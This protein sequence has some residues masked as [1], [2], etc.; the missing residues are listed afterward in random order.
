M[1]CSIGNLRYSTQVPKVAVTLNFNHRL[2]KM[3]SRLNVTLRLSTALHASMKA[4]IVDG[5]EVLAHCVKHSNDSVCMQLVLDQRLLVWWGGW[6]S[7]VSM[8]PG[9]TLYIP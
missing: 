2:K 5:D 9:D 4:K 8:P 6:P 1:L 3:Q 7:Y